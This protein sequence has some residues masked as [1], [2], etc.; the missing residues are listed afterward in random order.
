[1]RSGDEVITTPL[2]FVATCNA[3][4]Y[5]GADPVFVDV[6]RESLGMCPQSLEKY[7]VNNAEVRD[8]GLCWNRNSGK[9]IR[10]CLP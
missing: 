3:I 8:D 6:E 2:T 10:V 7:L 4:R 9:I 1:V 5:C